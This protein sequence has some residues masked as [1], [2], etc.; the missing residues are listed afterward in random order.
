[1]MTSSSPHPFP[2][3]GAPRLPPN[4]LLRRI[5]ESVPTRFERLLTTVSVEPDTVVCERDTRTQYVWF[6][7]EAIAST[8]VQTQE[9]DVVDVGLLGSESMIGTNLLSGEARSAISVVMLLGGRAS[10]M[11]AEDFAREV[12]AP[13]GEAFALCLRFAG[14]Y[15][16]M[17]SCIAACNARHPVE[18][19]LARWLLMLHDRV[20]GDVL[21]VTQERM[22]L[23]LATRRASITQA[24]NHLR[25]AGAIEYTRGA[26]VVR[27]RARLEASACSCYSVIGKPFRAG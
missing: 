8:I 10:R 27:D 22:A 9:G 7:H 4:R 20:T 26:L 5:G 23:T 19:R 11:R 24:A 16:A 1:M 25:G 15:Q 17:M 12:V 13:A 14:A 3:V 2:D 21:R 18:K 6:P